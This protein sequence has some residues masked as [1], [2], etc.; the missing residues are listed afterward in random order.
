MR[1][2]SLSIYALPISLW[3]VYTICV[4]VKDKRMIIQFAIISCD[5]TLFT[6]YFSV[7]EILRGF[8]SPFHSLYPFHLSFSL[9]L[10]SLPP[11]LYIPFYLS[12]SLSPSLSLLSIILFDISNGRFRPCFP[13]ISL[14][15]MKKKR[16][17][18]IRKR[19]NEIVIFSYSDSK[20]HHQ[21]KYRIEI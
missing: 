3:S 10:L 9:S 17:K 15:V 20:F 18:A 5:Q 13:Y 4:M 16:I 7:W 2:L 21:M 11:S 6:V 19:I 12:F 14:L 1:S 8:Y